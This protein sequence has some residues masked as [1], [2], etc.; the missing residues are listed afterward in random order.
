MS[1]L[2]AIAAVNNEFHPDERSLFTA[3]LCYIMNI[4]NY[5][6]FSRLLST[7]AYVFRFT[8]NSRSS[9]NKQT[10]PITSTELGNARKAWIK[11]CQKE[12]Y[13]KELSSITGTHSTTV[14]AA[15]TSKT[16]PTLSRQRRHSVVWWINP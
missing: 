12:I 10:G 7:T 13:W 11:D 5:S 4:F 14:K 2:H 16:A 9:G 6:T 1:D 8:Y 15:N 3:G